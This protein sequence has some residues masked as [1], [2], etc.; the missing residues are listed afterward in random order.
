MPDK[1]GGAQ[2][3]A[4]SV[5]VEIVGQVIIWKANTPVAA[6]IGAGLTGFG[7]S[8]AFFGFGVEA[9][10]RT[11]PQSRG[12][13]MGAFVAFLDLSLGVTGPGGGAIANIFGLESV[14][15]VGALSVV[16]SFAIAVYLLLR[17]SR[18]QTRRSA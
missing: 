16:G 9:V 15:F 5:L 2:V 3:A 18:Q 11:P 14:Y 7:Y 8:L 13:A 1:V 12:A 17:S 6:Y 4:A 10:R